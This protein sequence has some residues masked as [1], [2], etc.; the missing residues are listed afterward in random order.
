MMASTVANG[1]HNFG[2]YV[3]TKDLTI[4]HTVSDMQGLNFLTKQILQKMV[5]M[6]YLIPT[7]G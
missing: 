2:F 1:L 4:M 3:G 7:L 6:L 5:S